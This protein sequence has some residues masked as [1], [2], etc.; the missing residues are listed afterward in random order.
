[1]K[2]W[3]CMLL[4]AVLA[5]VMMADCALAESEWRSLEKFPWMFGENPVNADMVMQRDVYEEEIAQN[6]VLTIDEAGYDGRILLLAYTYKFK[7]QTQVFP[8][9]E[10]PWGTGEMMQAHNVGWWIDNLWI[11]GKAVD[12]AWGSS[13]MT[14]GTGEPG[15]VQIIEYWWLDHEDVALEDEVEISL[16]IGECQEL[17]T[18]S[19]H[20]EL[21]DEN[22]DRKLPDKGM[23]TFTFDAGD[24]A[25]N[26]VVEHPN[27]ETETGTLTAK[28]TEAAY[29][30]LLTYIEMAY[31][32]KPEALEAFIAENGEGY[33][34]GNGTLVHPFD[35]GDVMADD[36][37]LS[38]LKLVDKDGKIVGDE[39]L[40]IQMIG[41]KGAEFV[42]PYMEDMPDE[43]Y[44]APVE[45]DSANM[46]QAVKL[47]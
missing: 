44:L 18:R 42:I 3:T 32:V 14:T 2:K 11:D 37:W 28:I 43:L 17:V 7:N 33:K 39:R 25:K 19:E 29:S 27:I 41:E 21:F 4:A 16:P 10:N 46:E 34:D 35:A 1:M 20:P 36:P 12:M 26:V 24:A 8:D 38:D 6:V 30:P 47:R 22:G 45:K 9:D 40:N 13:G 31:E 23:V 15:E 5:L